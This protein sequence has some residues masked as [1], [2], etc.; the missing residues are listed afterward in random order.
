MSRKHLES[1]EPAE[2]ELI[3]EDDDEAT[4][5]E[6]RESAEKD[7]FEPEED[8]GQPQTS[9]KV[10]FKPFPAG[11]YR[12]LIFC[13][14]LGGGV[15][16]YGLIKGHMNPDTRN[17][18]EMTRS[19]LE[20]RHKM[21]PKIV[22]EITVPKVKA[23]AQNA[24]CLL[25][26]MGHPLGDNYDPKLSKDPKAPKKKN[27]K[28]ESD[29]FFFDRHDPKSPQKYVYMSNIYG[30]PHEKLPFMAESTIKLNKMHPDTKEFMEWFTEEPKEF[31]KEP[32]ECVKSYEGPCIKT[33]DGSDCLLLAPLAK[34]VTGANLAMH[35]DK[36]GQII[37][38]ACY[39]NDLHQAVAFVSNNAQGC[40]EIVGRP[41]LMLPGNSFHGLGL[42]MDL[43][44]QGEAEDYLVQI[45]VLCGFIHGDEA[46]CSFGEQSMNQFA[47]RLRAKLNK[48]KDRWKDLKKGVRFFRENR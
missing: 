6:G 25:N 34:A 4:E 32:L 20:G 16:G 43:A 5:E 14:L 10:S 13:A 35:D 48:W 39:R 19:Y 36:K 26:Q 42:A 40:K 3:E 38:M 47:G 17:P 9:E 44:N 28:R 18:E 22:G 1:Q 41:G 11:V 45:N 31:L 21:A 15:G 33:W 29:D 7:E 37:P 27:Y 12:T 2:D 46:H 30:Y 24:V 8:N 23:I